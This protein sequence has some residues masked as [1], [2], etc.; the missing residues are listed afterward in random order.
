M[1]PGLIY[2]QEISDKLSYHFFYIY[3]DLN[4]FWVG[5]SLF[6]IYELDEQWQGSR[7]G[8]KQLWQYIIP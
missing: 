8:L 2:C 6:S 7:S 3:A 1:L 4:Y 5:R